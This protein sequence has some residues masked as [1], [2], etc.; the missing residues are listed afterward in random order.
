MSAFELSIGPVQEVL[1]NVASS[2][3]ARNIQIQDGMVNYVGLLDE[4]LA[5]G[6]I[7]FL[8][9]VL[10][11]LYIQKLPLRWLRN[12]ASYDAPKRAIHGV[13]CWCLKQVMH[14]FCLLYGRHYYAKFVFNLNA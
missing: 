2:Y 3:K 14:C 8:L 9:A 4:R 6:L 10:A 5:R 1:E 11:R 13:G 7:Y 12:L